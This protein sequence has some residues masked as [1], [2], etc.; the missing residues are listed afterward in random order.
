M[1]LVYGSKSS[2]LLPVDLEVDEELLLNRVLEPQSV[3]FGDQSV[4]ENSSG[5]MDP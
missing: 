4:V 2:Y 5:F 1:S 3:F